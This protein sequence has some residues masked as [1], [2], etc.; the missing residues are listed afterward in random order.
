MG[1]VAAFG[2]ALMGCSKEEAVE[3]PKGAM[4]E[5]RSATREQR[6]A[7]AGGGRG[8]GGGRVTNN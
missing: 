2:M 8:E 7:R 6:D 1:L 3:E 5:T 4:P